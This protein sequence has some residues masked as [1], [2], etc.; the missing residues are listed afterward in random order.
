MTPSPAKTPIATK[1]KYR[2]F[3]VNQPALVSCAA[4]PG[5]VWTARIADVSRRGMQLIL[6][7]PALLDSA[8]RI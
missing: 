2:R 7:H 1:R 3:L 4:V 5:L 6:E 8:I